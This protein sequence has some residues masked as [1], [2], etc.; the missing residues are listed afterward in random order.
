MKTWPALGLAF[1]G[2]S[3]AVDATEPCSTLLKFSMAEHRVAVRRALDIPASA[4]GTSPQVPAHCRVEGIIDERT[5]RDGKPY[6]I[7]F[8]VSLPVQWTGR[9]LFQG[10]GGLNGSV[11]P[12]I[13]AQFAGEQSA[14][15]RGL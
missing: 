4:P 8:A 3:S 14:L 15:A 9:F 12:P 11:A 2:L 7:G 6:G 5:G 1:A 10:G 13:G